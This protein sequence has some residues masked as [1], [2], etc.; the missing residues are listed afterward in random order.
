[1]GKVRNDLEGPKRI[2]SLP[3]R[4]RIYIIYP[5]RLVG[6]A[7]RRSVTRYRALP[8]RRLTPTKLSPL[9]ATQHPIAGATPVRTATL[10]GTGQTTM[11]GVLRAGGSMSRAS[12]SIPNTTRSSI[13]NA[14]SSSRGSSWSCDDV[15]RAADTTGTVHWYSSV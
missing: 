7:C 2:H 5:S 12:T 11:R 1:M 8:P 15:T 6:I 14:R 3:L 9:T 4:T 13:R 10:I